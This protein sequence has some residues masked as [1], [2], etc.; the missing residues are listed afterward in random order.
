MPVNS[1]K[2]P[3]SKKT[4]LKDEVFA[5]FLHL[6]DLGVAPREAQPTEFSDI[7]KHRKTELT[8]NKFYVYRCQYLK[9]K[10]R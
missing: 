7:F 2:C 3:P 1:I 6:E 10:S 5:R 4:G 9:T 8:L